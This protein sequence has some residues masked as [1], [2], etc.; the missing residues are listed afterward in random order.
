[1][2]YAQAKLHSKNEEGIPRCFFV[3]GAQPTVSNF[4][5]QDCNVRKQK[6]LWEFQIW[7]YSNFCYLLFYRFFELICGSL[8]AKLYEILLALSPSERHTREIFRKWRNC[9]V[10]VPPPVLMATLKMVSRP[11][12]TK[13]AC[14]YAL[15]WHICNAGVP[16]QYQFVVS[17][18]GIFLDK[19]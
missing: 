14:V 17:A 6:P 9:G 5:G 18:A 1:M 2:S 7:K 15:F 19:T 10:S 11:T 13:A 3:A 4:S 16:E 8:A 12:T